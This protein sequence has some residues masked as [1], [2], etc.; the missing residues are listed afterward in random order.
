MAIPVRRALSS[1]PHE[2]ANA[3]AAHP[4]SARVGSGRVAAN[5]RAL[6]RPV[7]PGG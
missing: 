7:R 5:A 4:F 1:Q 6:Q 3:R 2:R